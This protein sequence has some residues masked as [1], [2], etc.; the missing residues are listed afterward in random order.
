MQN[1]PSCLVAALL[2]L[3]SMLAHSQ[4]KL[5]FAWPDGLQATV[6]Y[7][8]S[9][10]RTG[11]SA[12]PASSMATL[13][14]M[15]ASKRQSATVVSHGNVRLDPTSIPP[16]LTELERKQ[17]E[18][19]TKAALPAYVIKQSGDFDRID[20]SSAFRTA[21]LASLGQS[22]PALANDPNLRRMIDQITSEE[23]LNAAAS[24]EWSQYVGFWVG[25]SLDVG[26]TYTSKYQGTVP[27][28]PSR[29]IGMTSTF[30]ITGEVACD[31]GGQA[32]KCVEI[33]MRT[34]PNQSEVA[35]AIQALIQKVAPQDADRSP[36]VI[37]S[38]DLEQ[39]L[40]LVTEPDG[41]VPHRL[42]TR[43]KITVTTR[44]GADTKTASEV[45]DAV[46]HYVYRQK[47]P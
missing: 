46:A 42:S 26:E 11:S 28:L 41:L 9:R 12:K 5:E 27:L 1:V 8:K 40:L 34:T 35:G 3:T 38:I 21:L 47:A 7:T 32:K 43:K 19:M 36:E 37:D 24:A 13:Y 39:S 23:F 33:E 18:L 25:A 2:A 20:D 30:R 29:A 16:S 10:I 17:L 4:V 44:T 14:D 22:L 6:A 15:K 31:R 45:Q